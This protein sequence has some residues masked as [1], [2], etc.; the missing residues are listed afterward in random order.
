MADEYVAV[1]KNFL[2]GT[3]TDT[4]DVIRSILGISDPIPWE[5]DMG[6]RRAIIRV[7]DLLIDV[8]QLLD[9]VLERTLTELTN[10]RITALGANA[11]RQCTRLT[12]VTLNRIETTGTSALYS[13]TALK[14][15]IAP[16]LRTIGSAAFQGDTALVDLQTPSVEIIANRGL[17]GCTSLERLELPNL[18][19]IATEAFANCSTLTA[20]ILDKPCTLANTN[21]FNG[22]PIASGSG[23]IYVPRT[24]LD[25]FKSGTNWSTFAAKFRAKEDSPDIVGG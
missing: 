9:S 18:E 7:E 25:L 16:V 23:Y 4:A 21:A 19:D 24:Y 3:M 14:R 1:N 8:K 13:C 10:N 6:F 20:L 17:M 5:N 22:T 2:S 11:L 15:F 12:S